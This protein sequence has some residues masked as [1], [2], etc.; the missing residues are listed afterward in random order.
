MELV[1]LAKAYMVDDMQNKR[2]E[3]M[4]QIEIFQIVE[5]EKITQT[6]REL[7]AVLADGVVANDMLGF[8]MYAEYEKAI[9]SWF[10]RQDE[11]TSLI[12]EENGIE[13]EKL[14]L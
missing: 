3:L 5:V 12:V 11:L 10:K 2:R 8:V 6:V 4:K 7:E 9:K 1:A 13:E 14:I